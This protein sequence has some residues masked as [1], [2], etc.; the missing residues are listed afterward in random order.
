M[1]ECAPFAAVLSKR[2][3]EHADRRRSNGRS[4]LNTE[5]RIVDADDRAVDPGIVG[6]VLVR[7]AN[8][9]VGYY[10]QPDVTAET[11]RG[12][13][14]H[15][16]DAGYLDA[17]DYLHVVDR[18]KDVIITGGENVYSTEVEDALSRH[19]AVAS[20]AVVGIP[21]ERWGETVVAAVVLHPEGV[22]SEGELQQHCRAFIAGYKT[23][24]A[25]MF[26]DSLPLSGAGK[27][28]KREL[29]DIIT[30]ES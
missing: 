19:P 12:G 8:V 17:E 15:T 24:R 20:C 14:M 23:P 7:G 2:D 10:N 16:G 18:I 27:I 1:T 26:L 13:W 5:I 21:D 6:E 30:H 3:H 9:M 22:V 29:I 4:L 28:V 11:L 25:V